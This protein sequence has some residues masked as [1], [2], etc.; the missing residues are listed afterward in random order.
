LIAIENLLSE[1]VTIGLKIPHRD[2]L[3]AELLTEA[4]LKGKFIEISF[5]VEDVEI[6]APR[7]A[8]LVGTVVAKFAHGALYFHNF[9]CRQALPRQAVRSPEIEL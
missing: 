2:G 7:M 3:V 4:I 6:G 5:S 8:W 9:H 1:A